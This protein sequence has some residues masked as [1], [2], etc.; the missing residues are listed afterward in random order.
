M[1]LAVPATP[2]IGAALKGLYSYAQKNPWAGL[3]CIALTFLHL[4]RETVL[5]LNLQTFTFSCL[6]IPRCM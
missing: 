1:S 6:Y 4:G 3:I 2:P 5:T